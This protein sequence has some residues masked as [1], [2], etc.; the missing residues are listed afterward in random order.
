MAIAAEFKRASPSKGNINLDLDPVEQCV[1]Y[2]KMG[3]SLIS[4]LTEYRHFKGSLQD[5]KRV[6]LAVQK[7]LSTNRP[8][9]LRKDFVFDRYQVLEARAQGADTVLLI[10]AVLGKQQ[11]TD[12]IAFSRSLL[13]EPLVE[14]HTEKEVD[15]AMACGARV[16]GINNRNLHSFQLDLSVTARLARHLQHL[17][18][19]PHRQRQEVVVAALSGISTSQE[20]LHY[21]QMGVR[22]CLVGETLMKAGDPQAKIQELFGGSNANTSANANANASQA[23]LVKVC[24]LTQT[25]DAQDA[26]QQGA[27]LLGVV[28]VATRESRRS[29]LGSQDLARSIATLV[30]GYGER[31]GPVAELSQQA[32]QRAWQQLQQ[33]EEQKEEERARRWFRQMRDRLHACT[34]RRP[35]VVGVFQDQSAEEINALVGALGLDVAQLHGDEC[36][37]VLDSICVPCIKVLHVPSDARDVPALAEHVHEQAK[38]Y[39]GRALALLLDAK[40]ASAP[41][42]GG[43]G[44]AFDWSLLQLLEVPVMLAGG[45]TAHSITALSA[46]QRARLV[47]LDV[48]SG[49]EVKDRPGKKDKQAMRAFLRASAATGGA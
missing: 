7:E 48:S 5:M 24:G 11:L 1:Q 47:A 4:V 21:A 8:A 31:A 27:H 35:L 10:V 46:A 36:P 33:G 6:R 41:Y 44:Q 43:A 32:L 25:D 22:C 40:A 49:V 20:V 13:M 37:A 28:L 19:L 30:R 16:I 26:L 29:L 18:S 2:A 14:V 34:L 12:L 39:A 38:R 9:I 42:S 15:I 23:L 3:A 45:L 17:Q